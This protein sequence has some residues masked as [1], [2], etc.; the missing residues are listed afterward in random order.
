MDRVKS[1][2]ISLFFKIQIFSNMI[3]ILA[4]HLQMLNLKNNKNHSE[5]CKILTLSKL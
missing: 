4:K 1:V 5:I 3:Q 2:T